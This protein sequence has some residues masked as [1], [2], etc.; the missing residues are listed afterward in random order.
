MSSTVLT[1]VELQQVVTVNIA[2]PGNPAATWAA[3]ASFGDQYA[4]AA[5]Q[6]LTNPQL[7]FRSHCMVR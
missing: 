7:L 6:G 4:L 1:Q 2:N 5:L 3:L